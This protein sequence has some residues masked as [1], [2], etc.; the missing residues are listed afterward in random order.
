MAD[1]III[2]PDPENSPDSRAFFPSRVFFPSPQAKLA[3]SGAI[4]LVAQVTWPTPPPG[5]VSYGWSSLTPGTVQVQSPGT[6]RSSILG[7]RPGK[8]EVE[9]SAIGNGVFGQPPPHGTRRVS[10]FVCPSS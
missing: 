4:E 7:L 8:T 6:L 9:F 10:N 3:K 5:G 2:L 1:P